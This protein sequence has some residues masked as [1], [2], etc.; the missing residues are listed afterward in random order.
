MT[1]GLQELRD[2]WIF[3]FLG[4]AIVCSFVEWVAGH[5]LERLYTEGGGHY[6]GRKG[7]IDHYIC[8]G[9]AATGA[10]QG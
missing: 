4:A 1:I 2:R 9:A 3:L 7:C 8:L 10:L 6:S 5:L